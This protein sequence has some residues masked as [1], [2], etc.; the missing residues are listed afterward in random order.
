MVLI[1][2]MGFGQG[3][4]LLGRCGWGRQPGSEAQAGL[5]GVLGSI[6]GGGGDTLEGVDRRHAHVVESLHERRGGS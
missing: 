1:V 5:P 6:L 4:W 3:E 2:R